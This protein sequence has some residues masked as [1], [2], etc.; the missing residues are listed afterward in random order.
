MT[1]EIRLLSTALTAPTSV[2][3]LSGSVSIGYKLNTTAKPPASG[4]DLAEVQTQN[5]ENPIYTIS[6][7]R[8]SQESGT[9]TQKN[10]LELIRSRYDGTN[11]HTLNI[12]H[13]NYTKDGETAV[14]ALSN[15]DLATTDIPVILDS[16]TYNINVAGSTNA[17]LPTLTLIFKETK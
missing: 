8:L 10:L 4:N 3:L 12:T 16:A 13:S 2:K 5:Y 1:Q 9:L 7:I 6:G 15:T 14:I 17:Y 11:S